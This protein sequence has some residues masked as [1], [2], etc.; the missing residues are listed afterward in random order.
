MILFLEP[1]LKENVWGG[2]RLVTEFPY[3]AE[4]EHIGECWAISAHPHGDGVVKE[5]E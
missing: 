2:N 1:V 4:G 3:R 5:G